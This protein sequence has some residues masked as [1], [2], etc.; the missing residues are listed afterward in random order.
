MQK[1]FGGYN[2]RAAD[3]NPS[4]HRCA[5]LEM[6]EQA[7][8]NLNELEQNWPKN[9]RIKVYPPLK[10]P[11][12]IFNDM[13][14]FFNKNVVEMVKE[15]LTLE[16]CDRAIRTVRTSTRAKD[17]TE[18]YL[19]MPNSEDLEVKR[20]Y[21]LAALPALTSKEQLCKWILVGKEPKG[22]GAVIKV[23]SESSQWLDSNLSSYT[24]VLDGERFSGTR[25]E[26]SVTEAV[27][28][29]M[30]L[31]FLFDLKLPLYVSGAWR[32][33]AEHICG[34]PSSAKTVSPMTQLYINHFD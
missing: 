18:A 25:G 19:K 32:F 27:C 14:R 30:S 23:D 13:E 2:E 22:V 7:S 31:M 1:C 4:T 8:S 24:I 5:S 11:F 21:V 9:L 26:F 34:L 28:C 17:V 20:D 15:Y 12:H 29:C 6:S 3:G 10:D 16:R 33:L